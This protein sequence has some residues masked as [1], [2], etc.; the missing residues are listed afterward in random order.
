MHRDKQ[1]ADGPPL[2]TRQTGM[3]KGTAVRASTLF[4][5]IVCEAFLKPSSFL[6]LILFRAFP[7]W[8]SPFRPSQET[9]NPAEQLEADDGAAVF[10]ENQ[11]QYGTAVCGICAHLFCPNPGSSQAGVCRF[12]Q[13][14]TLHTQSMCSDPEHWVPFDPGSLTSHAHLNPNLATTCLHSLSYCSVS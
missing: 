10:P 8:V 2:E 9:A 5:C 7:S 11:K 13:S 6:V 14:W 3:L 1:A 4:S 12:L